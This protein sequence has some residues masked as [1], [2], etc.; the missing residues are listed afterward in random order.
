M[1]DEA[2]ASQNLFRRKAVVTVSMILLFTGI[3]STTLFFVTP[4][5]SAGLLAYSF[6]L[7][8]SVDAD[9][10]AAIDNVTRKLTV[11]GK[12]PTTVG[13]FFALGHSCVVFIVCCGIAI[14]G[15]TF[16]HRIAFFADVGGYVGATISGTFL[17]FIGC[18]NLCTAR[19]LWAAWKEGCAYGGHEH[20]A[21]GAFTRCCPSFFD[22]IKHPWQMLLVGFLFGLGFDTSSEV[23]LLGIVAVSVGDVPRAA[24]LLLPLMFAAGMSLF[25]TLNGILMAWAYGKALADSMQRLYYNLFLTLLS[26][27]VAIAV[28]SVELLGV[29]AQTCDLHGWFW[30][31]IGYVSDH[32]EVLGFS[33]VIVFIVSFSA[34]LIYFAKLFP[35]G[36]PFEDPAKVSLLKYLKT[37]K[38]ID[39]SGIDD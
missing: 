14:A 9:H 28:G 12:R 10:I 18:I 13:L 38:F 27:F 39:R 17:L 30:D 21:V 6:G 11:Q 32:F 34:A 19:T 7:R 20:A 35:G 24:V 2:E 36:Q 31:F 15:D 3:V 5:V 29:L 33:V 8:H 4:L 37:E 26:S 22:A 1:S 16:K 23:G 25:D